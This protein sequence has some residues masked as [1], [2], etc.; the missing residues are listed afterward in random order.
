M[1]DI[2][3]DI[4]EGA[5]DTVVGGVDTVVDGVTGSLP[6]AQTV[7]GMVDT[8]LSIVDISDVTGIAVDVLA[9]ILE[10]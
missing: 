8:G 6:S 5:V 9:G 7:R 1:F 10:G 4:V 3:G 2:L